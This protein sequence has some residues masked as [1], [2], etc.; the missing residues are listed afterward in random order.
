M[1][2]KV[3]INALLIIASFF[4]D[5]EKAFKYLLS[6]SRKKDNKY[7]LT[8]VDNTEVDLNE[9]YSQHKK[10]FEKRERTGAPHH[11][12]ILEASL[13]SDSISPSLLFGG[14]NEPCQTA[15]IPY[16]GEYNS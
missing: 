16:Y 7:F 10:A 8:Y 5:K 15:D 1:E 12:F 11:I 2:E 4:S 9:F 6:R 14:K 13:D 3:Y